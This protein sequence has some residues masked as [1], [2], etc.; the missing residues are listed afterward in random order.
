MERTPKLSEASDQDSNDSMDYVE[1]S[2]YERPE[3]TNRHLTEVAPQPGETEDDFIDRASTELADQYPNSSRED[4]IKM[5]KAILEAERRQLDSNYQEKQTEHESSLNEAYRKEIA[6]LHKQYKEDLKVVQQMLDRKLFYS[7]DDVW[8]TESMVEGRWRDGCREIFERYDSEYR[9]PVDADAPSTEVVDSFR[10]QELD[11]M[12]RQ[13]E[14]MVNYEAD[15]LG[16]GEGL[17]SGLISRLAAGDFKKEVSADDLKE[18]ISSGLGVGRESSAMR[19]ADQFVDRLRQ[20]ELEAIKHN[21]VIRAIASP[22]RSRSIIGED[23]T[24]RDESRFILPIQSQEFAEY[25]AENIKGDNDMLAICAGLSDTLKYGTDEEALDRADWFYNMAH[26]EAGLDAGDILNRV[27]ALSIMR[28]DREDRKWNERYSDFVSR[29]WAEMGLEQVSEENIDRAEEI[30]MSSEQLK[31]ELARRLRDLRSHLEYQTIGKTRNGS[32]K[33]GNG[34]N[35][36]PAEQLAREIVMLNRSIQHIEGTDRVVDTIR[37]EELFRGANVVVKD[38]VYLDGAWNTARCTVSAIEIDS[39][40][41]V[42]QVW[43]FISEGTP[44]HEQ[45]LYYGM[46]D[47]LDAIKDLFSGAY[48]R[49]PGMSPNIKDEGVRSTKHDLRQK[50]IR[51][52]IE[53]GWSDDDISGLRTIDGAY[54]RVASAFV[55]TIVLGERDNYKVASTISH[56][57]VSSVSTQEENIGQTTMD[58]IVIEEVVPQQEVQTAPQPTESPNLQSTGESTAQISDRDL[59]NTILSDKK[60]LSS[61]AREIIRDRNKNLGE[62]SRTPRKSIEEMLSESDI[63]KL[64]QILDENGREHT[65]WFDE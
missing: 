61:R 34:K 48:Y 32:S 58:D 41:T 40:E 18:T 8:N 16:V 43:A 38:P 63:R 2:F 17:D 6:A 44:T 57:D 60:D 9:K 33:S 62:L 1:P 13:H 25:V 14:Q 26:E 53:N 64:S 37:E 10:R 12:N 56:E 49:Q 27:E 29:H 11:E 51:E 54:Q 24:S 46:A 5:G 22:V 4:R 47:S 20:P 65:K 31:D 42:G 15:R 19:G 21:A 30:K 55:R 39:P 52:Q 59:F 3:G 28:G 36:S 23:G 50:H 35:L 7:P 45:H